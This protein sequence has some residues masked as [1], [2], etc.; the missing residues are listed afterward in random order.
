MT[1]PR[2]P[3]R[4]FVRDAGVFAATAALWVLDARVRGDGGAAATSVAALTGL[5]TALC[6]FLAHEWG[7]LAGSL[8]SGSVVHFPPGVLRPLLF[9]FDA[10]ANGR[11]QFFWMSGGG[12]LATVVA[13]GVIL[14][15]CPLDAWSGR[16]AATLAGAGMLVTF[17]LE[18]PITVRVARGAAL[19]S[20]AAYRKPGA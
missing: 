11:R 6:G 20:G 7:H 2:V 14:V 5:A 18:V 12:Y 9:H 3:L 17:A 19:P 10:A 13:V 16:L 4:F 15:A 8:A 1:T